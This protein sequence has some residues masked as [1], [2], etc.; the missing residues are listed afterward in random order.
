MQISLHNVPD[1]RKNFVV[2]LT[3]ARKPVL[4]RR[5][6]LFIGCRNIL[7]AKYRLVIIIMNNNNNNGQ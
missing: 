4:M 5:N 2:F 7:T 1:F 3:V 6:K